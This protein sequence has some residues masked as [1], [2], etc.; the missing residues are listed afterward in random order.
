M[1]GNTRWILC[2]NQPNYV[3]TWQETEMASRMRGRP[4]VAAFHQSW[5]SVSNRISNNKDF[6][7]FD[8]I[9][10]QNR[11]R[12][13]GRIDL[14]TAFVPRNIPFI[15]AV[16]VFRLVLKRVWRDI[17]DYRNG[18]HCLLTVGGRLR[19]VK[20]GAECVKYAWLSCLARPSR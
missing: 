11:I 17:R 6:D 4:C 19:G 10:I 18:G 14:S 3:A 1:Q 9:E 15:A 2:W 5:M 13:D 20:I 8:T 16:A 7:I 12:T